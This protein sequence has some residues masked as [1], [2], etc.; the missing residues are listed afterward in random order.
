MSH[1]IQANR[2]HFMA[3][4]GA[5]AALGVAGA[6]NPGQA[7]AAP[8]R[9]PV[10]DCWSK[11]YARWSKGPNPTGDPN[12]FPIGV[13]LQD[14]KNAGKFAEV[15]VNLYVSLWEGPTAQQLDE[16]GAAGMPV[17]CQ[18]K[19]EFIDRPEIVG[20][21]LG[22]EPDNAQ[23]LEGGGYGP[24]I[25]ATTSIKEGMAVKAA[26]PNRP[27]YLNLSRGVADYGWVGHGEGWNYDEYWEYGK[28]SDLLSCDVYPRADGLP[29][30]YP[31]K[32]VDQCYAFTTP[33]A[34]VW[35]ILETGPIFNENAKASP[36]EIL[37]EAWSAIIHGA[38][39]LVYFGH[40]FS[41]FDDHWWYNHD[42]YR[43][44]IAGL[45]AQIKALAPVLN[46]PTATCPTTV[47]S[48]NLEVPI[49]HMTKIMGKSSYVF[50]A[51]MREGSTK[52]TFTVAAGKRVTVVGENRTLPI[53]GGTFTDDFADFEVHIYRID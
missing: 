49:D 50:A 29:M 25:P 24:H 36:R 53:S 47:T 22:D 5:A 9:G 10:D 31:A 26:D 39:G 16:L 51:S 4:V 23:P 2:R 41:Q 28:A 13:W 17:M 27:T 44:T 20:W 34:V 8:V 40:Y 32:G 37:F 38:R 21:F 14:T 45:N 1:E 11:P 35:S 33:D 12:Y 52:G 48:S 7:Q 15:G 6:M 42:E 43:E 3:G 30:W 19:P 46:Q 18:Y